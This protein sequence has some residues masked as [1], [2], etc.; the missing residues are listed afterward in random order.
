MSSTA[1]RFNWSAATDGGSGIASYDLQ[2]GTSPGGS[3]LFNANVGNAL[4]RTVTGSSGQ[5][6][7][8]RV[9]G[10]DKA[11]NTGAWSANSDG[12][13][14]DAVAPRLTAV[15]ALDYGQLQVTFDEAVIGA[16]KT[17]NYTLTGSL[18]LAGITRLSD[19]QY[20][21]YTTDQTPGALYTLTVKSAVKDRAGNSI[22]P[23]HCSLPFRGGPIPMTGASAWRLY[24]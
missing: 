13:A 15:S 2:V 22:H 19:S 21:L 10:R 14:V 4:T 24:R 23:S 1:V 3:N 6:L 18:R 12:I 17:A 11:G 9:R 20:R 7:Y 16:D 8:A 5:T